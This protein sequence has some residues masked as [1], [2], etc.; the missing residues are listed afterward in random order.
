[1]S[2]TERKPHD[3]APVE[4]AA[5]AGVAEL[6]TRL[7]ELAD[8]VTPF[9]VRAVCDLGVADE[10]CDGPMPVAALA[11]RLGV[12]A[13]ALYRTLR[14]L[15]CQGI[16]TEVAD[17]TFA[18]T[19]LA[20][21]LRSDHPVSLRGAYPL[22][23][24]NFDA[25]ASFEHTVRTGRPAFEHV[26]GVPYYEWL[27]DAPRDAGRFNAIQR[28]GNRLELRVMLRAFDWRRIETIVDVGGG[29]GAFLAALL[30]RNR[31]L[32]GVLLDLPHAVVGAVELFERAGVADRTR[33]VAGSF[34]DK[35]PENADAYVL[36]RVLYD[37]DDERARA[38]LAGV[39]AAMHADSRLLVL[40]PLIV[41]GN[42]FDP[43]KIYDLLS[44]TMLGGRARS[45]AELRA[46][47][48]SVG[49]VAKAVVE[50][51]MLPL[52]EAARG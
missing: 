2:A 31:H 8:L 15:A 13:D 6:I 20:Q 7:Q 36:K 22:L 21:L 9:A 29:D 33:V 23:D 17:R 14:A 48:T 42:E 35:I 26:H 38:L 5:G 44:L 45:E 30:A 47:L 25:W 49:L 12:D 11:E 3:G 52:V 32:H 27:D 41:P 4:G 37:W 1:M 19:P 24:A 34:F 10:L 40:D 18:L 39:R 16:F 50:T 51:P 28:A 43:A 46:L